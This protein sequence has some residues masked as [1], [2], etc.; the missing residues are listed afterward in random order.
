MNI[1]KMK[2]PA[3]WAVIFSLSLVAAA[4][5]GGAFTIEKSV[6]AGG[7]AQNLAGGS[8]SIDGTLGQPLAGRSSGG[9]YDL[10]SGFWT[11]V[12]NADAN[13]PFDFDGDG[14]TDI[15]IFRPSVG[16]WWIN[17][18]SNNQTVAA[19]FGQSGDK[20]TPGD[21]DKDGKTDIA[22]WRPANGNYFV[23]RSSNNSFFSFPWGS[24]GDIPIGAAIVP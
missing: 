15:S 19:Q 8:F 3:A 7:G 14:R 2:F 20:P 16:E 10:Q 5:S 22:F 23:L 6:I 4:Q 24:N 17:R 21:F 11:N 18:S 13:A 12:T 1:Q 9:G